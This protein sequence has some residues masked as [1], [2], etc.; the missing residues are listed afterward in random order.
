[1]VREES[2]EH[3]LTGKLRKIFPIYD[4]MGLSVE[5]LGNPLSCRAPM[6]AANGNHFGVMH[7]GVLFSLSLIHI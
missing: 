5:R 6:N 2:R 4:Y 1:M 3:R 7:A